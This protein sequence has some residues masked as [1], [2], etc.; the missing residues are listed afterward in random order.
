MDKAW[1]VLLL[2][3][4]DRFMVGSDTW[5]NSQWSDYDRLIASN[6]EWLAMLPRAAAEAIAYKNA[7]R[8]FEIKV[9]DDLL[10]QR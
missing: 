10:G 8:L 3:H 2:K 5:V 9:T 6:R 4:S 1:E 7:E